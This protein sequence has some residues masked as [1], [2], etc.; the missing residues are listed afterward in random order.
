M[1]IYGLTGNIGTGKSTVAKIFEGLGAF[2]I[3]ADKIAREI[4]EPDKTAWKEI[5]EH[6]GV[7]VL[8]ADRSLN[9]K[10]LGE[11]VFNDF[12]ER[13]KLNKI[14]HPIIIDHIK[15]KI[16]ESHSHVIVIEAA[17]LE[18]GG[19]LKDMLNG[20]IAVTTSL[21]IQIER[22]KKRD[23]ISDEEAASRIQ[24]Q[25]SNKEKIKDAD[26]VIVNNSNIDNIRRQAIIIW[27]NLNNNS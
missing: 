8:N 5:V 15:K 1:K 4:V 11:I 13:K 2:I 6:F 12:E 7:A 21:E 26:F 3:D 19:S 18:K 9:R 27:N 25:V 14:T 24:S 22:I 23:G 16:S 17:L 10:E 20:V